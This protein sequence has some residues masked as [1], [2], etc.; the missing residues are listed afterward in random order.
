MPVSVEQKRHVP[1]LMAKAYWA[2]P[3]VNGTRVAIVCSKHGAVLMDRGRAMFGLPLTSAPSFVFSGTIMDAELVQQDLVWHLLVFDIALCAGAPVVDPLTKR[4][5]VLRILC[6]TLTSAMVK[7]QAKPMVRLAK[8]MMPA[9]ENLLPTFACDGVILTPDAEEPS[10]PGMA[11]LVLK[12][13]THHTLDLVWTDGME[14]GLWFGDAADMVSVS[15]LRPR[16]TLT[17]F[18]K[19]PPSSGGIIVEVVIASVTQDHLELQF[20]TTRPSKETPNNA[21][22]VMRTLVSAAENMSLDDMLRLVFPA[23]CPGQDRDPA[24]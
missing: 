5:S 24:C 19:T 21:L 10:R 11:P 22:C 9:F 16:V 15:K 12:L 1:I 20:L 14:G 6:D 2:S 8:D 17:G 7:F 18:P 13:K 23:A 4:L 3:K